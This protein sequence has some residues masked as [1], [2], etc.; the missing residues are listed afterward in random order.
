M[1]QPASVLWPDEAIE[2]MRRA[3]REILAQ[4]GVRVD[5]PRA[6]EALTAAGCAPGAAGRVLVP[7]AV[8]E[9]A[10]ALVPSEFTLLA[11]DPSRS[12][13]VSAAPGETFVHNSGEDPN[14]ADPL[15]GRSRPSTIRDQALAARVMHRL[16]YPQTINSLFWPSDVPPDLEPLYSY[17]VLAFETD[18]HVSSPCV[19]YAWQLAPLAAM[20]E[21]VAGGA[22]DRLQFA[23]DL[24]F[25]PISPLQLGA[26]VCD[27]LLETATHDIVVEI[28]PCPMG[29]TTAPA[30]LAGA[31][32]QQHAEVLAGVVLTQAVRPGAPTFAGARLGPSHPRSGELLGGAPEAALASLGATQLARRDGLACDCYGPTSGAVVLD[33][34][35]GFEQGL[36]LMLSS[37][38]RPRFLSG[39][40]TM[41][42]TASC[43]EALVI[44]D[45][46][47]A[48]AFNGLAARGWDDEA[49]G[50]AAVAEAVLGGKGFLSLK[51]TRRHLRRDVEQPV[52]GFRGGID[53]WLA[54]GRT[55]VV[56]EARARVEQLC[57]I[58]PPGLPD[59]V[60][61]ELCG[62]VSATAAA[63]GLNEWP[64]PRRVLDEASAV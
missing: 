62:I 9:A 5:S 40:G 55:S 7:A 4:V 18:K 47:F 46:L 21:A 16:R 63:R 28:L 48:H 30:S 53:E 2:A 6:A 45:Q 31:I 33:M 37:L 23:L 29:A 41:Q 26:E 15:S 32:A 34:Q 56:E 61:A 3:S 27:G 64:D 44:H 22:R 1:D 25:S 54:T 52:T 17:L 19:D 57:A 49:L 12:V 43:L 50:V 13:P 38:A 10:L 36:S 51:H 42:A 60:V 58:A 24:S 14:V 39:C 8:V 20:A 11:R 35:A 59:D